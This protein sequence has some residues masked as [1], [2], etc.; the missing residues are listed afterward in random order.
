MWPGNATY[1]VTNAGSARWPATEMLQQITLTRDQPG[2]GGNV[3]YNMTALVRSVDALA[4]RLTGGPYAGPA[5]VPASP[6]LSSVP[7]AAPTVSLTR[8]GRNF[9]LRISVAAVRTPAAPSPRW[10]L[11]RARYADGWHAQVSDAGMPSVTLS[12]GGARELPDFVVVTAIDR[13]GVES[14]AVRVVSG[15][16]RATGQR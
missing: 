5:L 6:W 14:S 13:A 11:V 3:H 8:S 10:W 16:L 15:G 4:D 1:K 9:T 12:P 7:P 2:A